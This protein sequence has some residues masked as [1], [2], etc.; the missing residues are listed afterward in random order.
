MR[1]RQIKKFSLL[2]DWLISPPGPIGQ[3][4]LKCQNGDGASHAL[5][6]AR[7]LMKDLCDYMLLCS[8]AVVLCILLTKKCVVWA[9]RV[10][11]TYSQTRSGMIPTVTITFVPLFPSITQIYP[12]TTTSMQNVASL[13]KPSPKARN[14]KKRTPCLEE[15]KFAQ[16]PDLCFII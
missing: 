13:M 2:A 7:S 16:T 12:A 9:G 5:L 1:W 10:K 3:Q 15:S 6:F 8:S 11:R 4:C 14:F